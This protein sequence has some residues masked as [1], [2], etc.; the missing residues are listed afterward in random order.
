[1]SMVPGS[2]QSTGSF[3]QESGEGESMGVMEYWSDGI[4]GGGD[5][6]THYS[7][8]IIQYSSYLFLVFSQS[9]PYSY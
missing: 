7:I 6:N 5:Q 8:P 1:M 3:I 4:L 9:L 2:R